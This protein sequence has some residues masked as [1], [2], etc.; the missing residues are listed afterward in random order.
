MP[1]IAHCSFW[2]LAALA[3]LAV[4]AATAGSAPATRP[5]K[6]AAY[7]PPGGVPE[8]LRIF[9]AGHS[10]HT[11]ISAG[12]EREAKAAGIRNQSVGVLFIGGSTVDQVWRS[13][14]QP[15]ANSNVVKEALRT[16]RVDVLTL[17]PIWLP[18]E[19][20]EQFARFGLEHNPN[21]RIT[22]QEFW[23]PN[24]E[25]VP[26]Y[27]LQTK[28]QVDHDAT[29]LAE[30]RRAQERYLREL[31]DYVAGLNQKIGREV[32]HTVPVGQAVVALREKMAAGQAPGLG[33]QSEL[34]AD[35]W[36]HPKEAIKAMDTY[37]HFAVIYHRT[38]V[39]LPVDGSATDRAR[40]RLLQELAW[41]AVIHDPLSGVAADA[42]A[43][44]P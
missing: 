40:H 36:G 7:D 6:V 42:P 26:V 19:G 3:P 30:L 34:F 4:M 18:D 22:V 20:I 24:D 38:P 37:C 35:S 33:K 32:L 39:G 17:S 10:F 15:E 29:N 25:Y 9:V 16:G 11:F 2:C 14:S 21:L 43:P 5:G 23:L 27:P 1:T 12:L 8:G 44:R 13:R 31:N 28:K 41:E